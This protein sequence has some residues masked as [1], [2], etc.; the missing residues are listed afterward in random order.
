MFGKYLHMNPLESRKQLLIAESERNR[1]QLAGDMA[2]LT[3]GVRALTDRAQSF[4]SIASSAASLIAGL[5]SLRHS[6]SARG[7]GRPSW[8]QIL[9]KGTGLVSSCWSEF[10]SQGRNQKSK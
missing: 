5:A 7:E 6:K 4:A 3:A 8:W 9:L 1:A 10:R 2:A